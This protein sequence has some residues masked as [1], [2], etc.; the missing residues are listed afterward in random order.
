MPAKKLLVCAIRRPFVRW[1]GLAIARDAA[2]FRAEFFCTHCKMVGY[3][4]E[5]L[6]L[7]WRGRCLSTLV[8]YNR[9]IDPEDELAGGSTR[10]ST[11]T[12]ESV[13][14]GTP[15][16]AEGDRRLHAGNADVEWLR[17]FA[18]RSGLIQFEGRYQEKGEPRRAQSLDSADVL[19]R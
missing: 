6:Q 7:R 11:N 16:A 4:Q 8:C 12:T 14:G 15:R 13:V 18:S 2:S 17:P 10:S 9:T 3:G 5:F 19:A 1:G